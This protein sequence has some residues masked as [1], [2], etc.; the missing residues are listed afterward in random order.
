MEAKEQGCV[1]Y[2]EECGVCRAAVPFFGET[3]RKRGFTFAALQSEWVRKR[4]EIPQDGELH[5]IRLLLPDGRQILGADV[6]RYV[7]RRVWWSWPIYLLSVVPL[8]RLVFDWGYRMFANNRYWVARMCG[9]P[10]AG[11][12]EADGR[13]VGDSGSRIESGEPGES[14]KKR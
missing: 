4:I 2:D 1:L 12:M 8:L 14:E 9:L 5:Y 3:L 6:Y 11:E 10:R 13:L 7:M